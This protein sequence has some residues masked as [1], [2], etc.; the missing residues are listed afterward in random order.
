VQLYDAGNPLSGATA[1]VAS[2]GA[3]SA[4]AS[5]FGVTIDPRRHRNGA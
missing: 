2:N 3:T 4:A 5:A 1:T